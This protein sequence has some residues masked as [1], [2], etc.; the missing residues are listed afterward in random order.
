MNPHLQGD[1]FDVRDPSHPPFLA[2][3]SQLAVISYRRQHLLL[4]YCAP[5][6]LFRPCKLQAVDLDHHT[7]QLMSIGWLPTASSP[8]PLHIA[9]TTQ[10][11]NWH[12]NL[13]A[14]YSLW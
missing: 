14:N 12:V 4:A 13:D 8:L 6:D 5:A 10:S 9:R 11:I 2:E 3:P 7:D 1:P